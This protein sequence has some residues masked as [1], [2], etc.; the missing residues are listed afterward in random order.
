MK[1]GGRDDGEGGA[2][3]RAAQPRTVDEVRDERRRDARRRLQRDR[4]YRRAVLAGL[5]VSVLVH[6]AL[7]LFLAADIELPRMAYDSPAR[8]PVLPEGFEVVVVP[9]QTRPAPP[10]TTP[11]EQPTPREREEE[12][13]PEEDEPE[14]ATGEPV[15]SEQPAEEEGEGLTNAE[16]LQPREGDGRLWRDFWDEDRRKY[17]GSTRADSALRAILGEYFDSLRVSR[18]AYDEARD[19]TFGEGEDRWGVSPDGIHLGDITIPI[20]VDQFLSPTGPRRRELERELR[21]LRQIQRQETLRQVEE[22]REERIEEMRER[23]RRQA[24]SDS[25]DGEEGSGG[26]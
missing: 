15:P 16:K 24:E 6:A 5:G 9:E 17:L 20:P 1:A 4:G 14:E 2:R 19:W 25:T 7:A 10:P 26:G 22:T 3:N 11:P 13:E 8:P 18:E 23:S 21:E 12:Q